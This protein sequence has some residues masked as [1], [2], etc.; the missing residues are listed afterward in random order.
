MNIKSFRLLI[1]ILLF[2]LAKPCEA[3]VPIFKMIGQQIV[4]RI[5]FKINGGH[6]SRKI[7]KR[8]IDQQT[9]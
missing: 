7:Q 4:E 2:S 6:I 8:I 5:R 1:V 9:P 3:R